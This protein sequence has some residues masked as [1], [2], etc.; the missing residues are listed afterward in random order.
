MPKVII[1][2]LNGQTVALFP[3]VAHSE[4]VEECLMVRENGAK[5]AI[6]LDE[7]M[8]N[9][10]EA[11]SEEKILLVEKLE[12]WGYTDI[13]VQKRPGKKSYDRRFKGAAFGETGK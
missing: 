13:E 7:V 12:N 3:D 1:R 11:S 5:G 6:N 8:R 2:M 9:S 4:L 10:S